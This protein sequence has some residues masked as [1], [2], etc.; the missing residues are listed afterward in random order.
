MLCVCWIWAWGRLHTAGVFTGCCVLVGV[1]KWGS[2][3]LGMFRVVSWVF[4][5]GMVSMI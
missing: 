3:L 5:F 2:L 1:C 4:R